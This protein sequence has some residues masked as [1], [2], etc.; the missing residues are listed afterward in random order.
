[1]SKWFSKSQWGAD[2]S[3]QTVGLI[4][5]IPNSYGIFFCP[6]WICTSI[7][8]SFCINTFNSFELFEINCELTSFI[9]E[10]LAFKMFPVEVECLFLKEEE[11]VI[12]WWF[13]QSFKTCMLTTFYS[14]L[15]VSRINTSHI[16]DLAATFFSWTGCDFFFPFILVSEITIVLFSQQLIKILFISVQLQM[17]S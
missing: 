16:V 9:L 12:R 14:Q 4:C 1:M 6:S 11:D 8:I 10:K 17:I 7:W 13:Q 2:R 5:N 15:S 3:F